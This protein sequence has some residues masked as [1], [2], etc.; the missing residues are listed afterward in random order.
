MH[1]IH[2]R[3]RVVF[4]MVVYDLLL[5]IT[6]PI[7]FVVG[8]IGLLLGLLALVVLFPVAIYRTYKYR[9]ILLG[10][11]DPDAPD[12]YESIQYLIEFY[13]HHKDC[14]SRL[15]MDC[16]RYVDY[17]YQGHPQQYVKYRFEFCIFLGKICK[18]AIEEEMESNHDVFEYVKKINFENCRDPRKYWG[19]LRV[20]DIRIFKDSVLI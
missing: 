3:L 7:T 19:V 10:Y 16:V 12:A 14:S 15:V 1:K 13:A 4:R 2:E 20:D 9:E 8:S 17:I 11:Q 6:L 5:I 18:A